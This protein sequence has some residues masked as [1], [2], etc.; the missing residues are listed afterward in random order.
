MRPTII[1]NTHYCVGNNDI[2]VLVVRYGKPPIAVVLTISSSRI[3][4]GFAARRLGQLKQV[5]RDA[6]W[7]SKTKFG[8]PLKKSWKFLFGWGKSKKCGVFEENLKGFGFK[9]ESTFC[10]EQDNK[11]RRLLTIGHINLK[12]KIELNCKSASGNLLKGLQGS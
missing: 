2:L 12:S 9:K 5:W 4:L 1:P 11:N 3:E 7:M 8:V 10:W 6:G